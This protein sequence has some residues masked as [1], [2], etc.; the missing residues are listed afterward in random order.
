M[1]PPS[2]PLILLLLLLFYPA[3][4]SSSHPKMWGPE[5]FQMTKPAQ[6][7]E[8]HPPAPA[9][10]VRD[11]GED[12]GWALNLCRHLERW[13]SSLVACLGLGGLPPLP[14]SPLSPP[15]QPLKLTGQE[16]GQGWT[17]GRGANLHLSE[18]CRQA[19]EGA[20]IPQF[21]PKLG[22]LENEKPNALPLLGPS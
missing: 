7:P 8:P 2:P 6:S 5:S 4:L 22:T 10:G 13:C 3:S 20:C 17:H 15:A 21:P 19:A 11:G 1:W 14:L 9:V 18:P 12:L 16:E